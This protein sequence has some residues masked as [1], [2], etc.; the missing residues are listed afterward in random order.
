MKTNIHFFI[1]SR[2]IFLI[3][4]NVSDKRCRENQNTQFVFSNSVFE[5]HA[6]Y[7]IMWKMIVEWGRTQ[8]TVWCMH[9]A[10]WIPKVTNTHTQVVK[11]SLLFH[12]NNGCTN[13]PQCYFIHTLPVLFCTYCCECPKTSMFVLL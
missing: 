2:S 13:A 10:C 9:I 4:R 12:C 1:S 7:E 11:Y 8:M 5:N 3:M 6:T